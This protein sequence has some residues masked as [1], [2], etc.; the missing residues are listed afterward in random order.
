MKGVRKTPSDPGR[1]GWYSL[2]GDGALYR[3]LRSRKRE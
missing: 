2:L 3:D 1:S